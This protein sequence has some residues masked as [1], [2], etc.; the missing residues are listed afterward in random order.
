MFS[1]EDEEVDKEIEAR[2]FSIDFDK[3]EYKELEELQYQGKDEQIWTIV[4]KHL[5]NDRLVKYICDYRK[6]QVNKASGFNADYPMY[7][8]FK[9]HF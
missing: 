3:G 5:G 4:K 9:S 1:D 6:I 8:E 7:L 2:L